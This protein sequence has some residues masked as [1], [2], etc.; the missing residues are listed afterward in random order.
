MKRTATKQ[1]KEWMQKVSSMGCLICERLGFYGTPSEVHHVHS[2]W[3][4]DGHQ[5]TIPLCPEHHRGNTGIHGMGRKAFEKEYGITQAEMLE[6]VKERLC[7]R[8]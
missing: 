4:R 6:I 7:Q 3:G 2:G 1:D 8:I 5:N